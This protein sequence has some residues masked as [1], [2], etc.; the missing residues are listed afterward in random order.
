M[1]LAI[2]TGKEASLAASEGQECRGKRPSSWNL[3]SVRIA[4]FIKSQIFR[5]GK[6]LTSYLN[7]PLSVQ[8]KALKLS[9]GDFT[10]RPLLAEPE[11]D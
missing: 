2:L 9:K 3:S 5:I 8:F 1:N 6:V 7:K 10:V 11:T 4:K